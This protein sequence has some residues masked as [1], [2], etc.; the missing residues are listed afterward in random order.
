MNI[1]SLRIFSLLIILFTALHLIACNKI[2]P[3]VVE[4]FYGQTM[5]TS[6]TVS[7]STLPDSILLSDIKVGVERV[8]EDV[9]QKMSTYKND[10]EVS[11]FNLAPQQEWFDISQN[12]Y[13]VIKE[14]QLISKLSE[15]AFD[16][17][18]GPIVNLWG[19]GPENQPEE[20]PDKNGLKL[21]LQ[22]VGYSF[23]HLHDKK[24]KIKKEKNIYL[25]L[26]AI[27]KGYAVDQVIQYLLAQGIENAL[28]EIGGELRAIGQKE[29]GRWWRI[30]IET[31]TANM[32][33]VQK[34]IELRG[35]GLATSGDYR[36][37]F[38]V[39]GRRYSHTLNPKTGYP[40][41]H[42]LASVSVVS[43]NCMKADGLATAL[44]VLGDVKG[45]AFADEHNIAAFFIVKTKSGFKEYYTKAFEHYFMS[46]TK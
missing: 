27:A 35:E 7:I 20:V 11:R 41:S 10:S 26:S 24:I 22:R 19:F 8:L 45:K 12:T 5:G 30:A 17:T 13:D 29:P 34:I 46:E 31:P 14:G 42:K 18:I 33:S 32:R 40:I 2:F 43:T 28:V 9:N 38:E 4:Q 39:D 37:Y 3:P 23:L 25:D 36:N 16:M 44:L 1:S 15:G 6:Y 21:S